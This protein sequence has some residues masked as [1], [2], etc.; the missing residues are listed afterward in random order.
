MSFRYGVKSRCSNCGKPVSREAKKCPHCG[1][2]FSGERWVNKKSKPKFTDFN[3]WTWKQYIAVIAVIAIIALGAYALFAPADDSVSEITHVN[4]LSVSVGENDVGLSSVLSYGY[5]DDGG[6]STQYDKIVD[7][8]VTVVLMDSNRN[9]T[10][11]DIDKVISG[12]LQKDDSLVKVNE[13]T[14]KGKY[15]NYTYV[16]SN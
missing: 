14:I 10:Q 12:V 16:V 1:T 13:T 6:V 2:S 7:N 3:Q 11:E 4:E 8:K 9:L 5:D 15:N